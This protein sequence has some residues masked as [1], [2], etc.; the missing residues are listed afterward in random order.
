MAWFY[1]ERGPP[2]KRGW[3]QQTLSSISFP[4]PQLIAVFAIVVLFL[5]MSWYVDYRTQVR[6]A[7]AG[8]RLLLFFLPVALFFV[9][10]YIFLD[11]RFVFQLPWPGQEQMRRAQSSPW[12]VAVLVGL[13]LVMASYQPSFHSQWLRPWRID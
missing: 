13:L 10:R 9:A 1:T 3:T 7:E 11:G 5:S 8:F 12:G 2:W 4:P 6:R